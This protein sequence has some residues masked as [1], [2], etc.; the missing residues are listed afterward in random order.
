MA[1]DRAIASDDYVRA[2]RSLLA[3]VHQ[4]KKSASSDLLRRQGSTARP[5]G[6]WSDALGAEHSASPQVGGQPLSGFVLAPR[7]NYD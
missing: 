5:D 1:G 6:P 2:S 7:V 4:E 3:S